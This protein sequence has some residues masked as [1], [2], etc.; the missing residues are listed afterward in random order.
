MLE[1]LVTVV[2]VGLIFAIVWW[3]ISQIPIPEPFSW[4]VR[5]IFALAVVIVL[6]GLLTGGVNS[7]LGLHWHSGCP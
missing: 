6:V 4:V 3:A 5:A 1:L 7:G 2:I